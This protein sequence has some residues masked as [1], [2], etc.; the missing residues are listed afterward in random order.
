MDIKVTLKNKKIFI[1]SEDTDYSIDCVIEYLKFNNFNSIIR[2]NSN[3]NIAIN[4]IDSNHDKFIVSFPE[5]NI[6]VSSEE[7]CFFLYRRG[8][9][10]R[11]NCTVNNIDDEIIKKKVWE[12]TNWEWIVCRNFILQKLQ[13]KASWGNYFKRVTNK[14]LNLENAKECK[15]YIPQ[16]IVSESASICNV[17]SEKKSYITKAIGDIMMIDSEDYVIDLSTSILERIP[18]NDYHPSLLQQKVE[19]W[20]ELRVFISYDKIFA[21]SIFSQN[22]E[23]TELDFRNYDRKRMN[24]MVPFKLPLEIEE[25]VKRF[26]KKS[27]YDTGSIDLILSPNREY[28]FLEINPDGIFEMISQPC[29]YY[30]EKLIAEQILE[31]IYI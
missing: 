23:K 24:R 29:N 8:V 5:K 21:M 28:F 11:K 20:V 16:T 3:D 17:I 18:K 15:F 7:I 1:L 12:F 6:Y 2:C 30:I 4:Q 26:M 27:G 22:N 25:N 10:N 31:R 9:L 14:L 13:S 19:K